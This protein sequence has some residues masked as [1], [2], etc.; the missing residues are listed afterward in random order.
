MDSGFPGMQRGGMG[1]HSQSMANFAP[2]QDQPGFTGM[3]DLNKTS[4]KRSG[5]PSF[6]K[7][8]RRK[9]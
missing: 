1:G 6:N 4:F 5:S 7:K 8:K 9:R 3:P 2:M